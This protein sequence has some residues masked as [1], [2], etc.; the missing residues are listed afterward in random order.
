MGLSA[1]LP[2]YNDVAAL[3][4]VKADKGLFHFDNSF[5]PVPLQ[6]QYIGITEKKPVRRMLL[7]NEILYEKVYHLTSTSVLTFNRLW[8]EPVNSKSS[9]SSTQD[10]RP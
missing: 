4:R 9:F 6:Q 3:I 8:K 10:E 7:M 2:N 1:T 5:R